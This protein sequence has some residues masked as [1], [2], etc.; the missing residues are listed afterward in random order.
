MD[1]DVILRMR[2]RIRRTRRVIELAHDPKMIAML[3]QMVGEA[4]A[5]LEILEQQRMQIH[6]TPT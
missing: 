6:Q 5:D 2:D 4:E 3:E 1:D